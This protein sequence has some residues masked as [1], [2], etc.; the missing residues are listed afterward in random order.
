MYMGI[1]II[2][3]GM[4]DTI[5][6]A[7]RYGYQHLGINP[8]GAMDRYAMAIAN[9][10]AGNPPGEAAIE[11]HF[12]ASVFLFNQPALIAWAGADFSA[13]I[14]GEPVPALHPVGV[15]KNDVL[16]FHKPVCGARTYLAVQGGFA[17]RPWLNSRSTHLKAKAGGFQGR[18][19]RKNDELLFRETCSL[20]QL[21]EQYSVLHWKADAIW[22]DE[23]GDEIWVL[24][25][26]EWER[27]ATEAKEN[28]RMTSFL[29]TQQSDRMGYRLDNIPLPVLQRGELVSTAVSFGTVQLLPD[30][31]LIVLMADHQTT[32]GY[33]RIAHVIAAH[34]SK[35]AQLKAGDRIRFALTSHE[36]AEE[37]MIR[38]QQHLQ[39]L[40][41][42][43]T[44]RMEEFIKNQR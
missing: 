2:K 40:Q 16:Q 15:C 20:P 5:Q 27:L 39:Y 37:L 44:F 25:G 12:P 34:H 22:G 28:F 24:P 11:M 36:K 18:G 23:A 43:C 26:Q 4:L 17:I 3:A 31:K 6:D 14:N 10:L 29:V 42:A 9:I 7:G 35:L 13:S 21:P 41:N 1:T 19:L 32:G 33:P 38:Q 8:S 30:G